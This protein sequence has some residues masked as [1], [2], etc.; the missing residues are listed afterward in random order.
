[1]TGQDVQCLGTISPGIDNR[2][3]RRKVRQVVHM[4]YNTLFSTTVTGWT[5]YRSPAR[6][7][8]ARLC[9]S[10]HSHGPSTLSHRPSTLSHRPSTLSHRPSTLSHRPSTL[11]HRPSTL[12]HRP[13]SP[14][15]STFA[16]PLV[17]S[18]SWLIHNFRLIANIRCHGLSL[19]RIYH[20]FGRKR[21]ALPITGATVECNMMK[22][23]KKSGAAA[24]RPGQVRL[25][26]A[27][28]SRQGRAIQ[29][30]QP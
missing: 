23:K 30:P 12:S 4:L 18:L 26:R 7:K 1:M 15:I 21:T 3:F 11:S 8:A 19:D 22:Q 5:K 25:S 9:G 16:V 20:S 27:P 14:L 28:Q 29:E 10:A 17:C 2:I 6:L 24:H 13:S